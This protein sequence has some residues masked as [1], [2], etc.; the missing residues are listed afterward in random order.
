MDPRRQ[1]SIR[2][3]LRYHDPTVTL[4][5]IRVK[6]SDPDDVAASLGLDRS[7]QPVWLFDD[8]EYRLGRL[9]PDP[10]EAITG[11]AAAGGTLPYYPPRLFVGREAPSEGGRPSP[12]AGWR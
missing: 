6:N 4:C 12:S 8:A 2:I 10:A 7:E 3:E 1:Q 11:A 9:P 5:C